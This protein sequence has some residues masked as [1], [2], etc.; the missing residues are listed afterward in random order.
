MMNGY[1]VALWAVIVL[2]YI[3]MFWVVPIYLEAPEIYIIKV[4]ILHGMLCA[5]L[6]PVVLISYLAVKAGY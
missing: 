5:A 4:L 1:K 2:I 6:F 3:V